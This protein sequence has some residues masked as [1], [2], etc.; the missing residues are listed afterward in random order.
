VFRFVF[1]YIV[2]FNFPFPLD[3]IP[4]IDGLADHFYHRPW[5]AVAVRIG[6]RFLSRSISVIEN[7]RDRTVDFIQLFLIVAAATSMAVTWS[8]LDARRKEYA[9]L[10]EWLRVYVRY[11]LVFALFLYAAIK[12]VKV[13][14]PDP[15]PDSLLQMYGD[16]QPNRLLWM[17][18]GHSR[19]YST[20]VGLSELL[21]GALLCFRRTTTLGALV[22]VVTLLNVVLLNFCFPGVGVVIW[23]SN[24]LFLSAFLLMP[25]ARRL[26]DMLVLNRPTRPAVLAITMSAKWMARTKLALK[27]ALIGCAALAATKPVTK[28]RKPPPHSLYGVY[29]VE[30]FVRNGEAQ[31]LLM[32]DRTC[33]RRVIFNSRGWLTVQLMDDRATR[34]RTKIDPQTSII[35]LRGWDDDAGTKGELT[36]SRDDLQHLALEGR[37]FDETVRVRLRKVDRTFPLR[38]ARFR[39]TH[40]GP[41]GSVR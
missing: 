19:A 29:E 5:Q 9:R 8:L 39:W 21:A 3:R 36:Y 4:G 24:L 38:E 25:D 17:F 35:V 1:A 18:M 6:E 7:G 31:P 12:I 15:D 26:I 32:T 28:Y 14:F 11:L 10:H 41:V 22:A 30:E 20:F 33:F 37:F 13:Q 34:F 40:D 23:S 16:S 27:V 2:L